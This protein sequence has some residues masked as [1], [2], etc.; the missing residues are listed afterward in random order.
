MQHV[1]IVIENGVSYPIAYKTYNAA[2]CAVKDKHAEYL[3][4]QI[5]ELSTLHDIEQV[6]VDVNLPENT[7]S[8]VTQLYIEKGINIIITKLLIETN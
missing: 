5:K 8:S 7:N 6:L 4:S 1:Y 3:I 2:V